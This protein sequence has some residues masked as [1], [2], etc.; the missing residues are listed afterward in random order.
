MEQSEFYTALVALRNADCRR[1]H[2]LSLAQNDVLT[3]TS[4]IS[5]AGN[6][7]A[8]IAEEILL[9]GFGKISVQRLMVS[10]EL[11]PVSESG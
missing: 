7:W 8:Q 10:P 9:S 1:F 5:R 2:T 11:M 3:N 4:L 6:Q